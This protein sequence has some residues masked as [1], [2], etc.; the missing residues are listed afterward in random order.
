MLGTC[1]LSKAA[2]L[3]AMR[4]STSLRC[5]AIRMRRRCSFICTSLSSSAMRA[6]VADRKA[7]S[8]AAS[9]A[10]LSAYQVSCQSER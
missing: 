9:A 7:P 3:P 6:R 10:A 4:P 1:A 5:S 2:R 8:A